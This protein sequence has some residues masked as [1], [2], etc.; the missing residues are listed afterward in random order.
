[1]KPQA[2][3]ITPEGVQTPVAP[4]N[5]TDFDLTE[6]QQAVGGYIQAVQT[7]DGRL[8]ICDEEGKLKGKPV[9]RTATALYLHGD[10]DPICGTVLVCNET[11]F[12]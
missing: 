10:V 3:I 11:Q 7:R 8:L 2:I 1:M 12:L 6:C 4:R 9:N 5:G